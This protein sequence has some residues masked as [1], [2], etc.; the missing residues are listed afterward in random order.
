MVHSDDQTRFAQTLIGISDSAEEIYQLILNEGKE[1]GGEY[2]IFF[3]KCDNS[4]GRHGR[5]I[6]L[7]SGEFTSWRPGDSED[8]FL[9]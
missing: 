9:I 4:P 6:R 8:P 1:R 3:P 7:A 2:Y 5:L